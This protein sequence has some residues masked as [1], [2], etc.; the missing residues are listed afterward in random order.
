MAADFNMLTVQSRPWLNGNFLKDLYCNIPRFERFKHL[1]SHSGMRIVE[2]DQ[3]KRIDSFRFTCTVLEREFLT[4]ELFNIK[5]YPIRK[6]KLWA[7]YC[8]S[9]KLLICLCVGSLVTLNLGR[10]II[11]KNSF[12]L[13]P[14][15]SVFWIFRLLQNCDHVHWHAT[16]G[17]YR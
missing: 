16:I 15:Y 2:S 5:C 14:L 9:L 10:R 17:P 7:I 1:Q 3:P 13:S 11:M 4:E 12:S 8:G 6:W